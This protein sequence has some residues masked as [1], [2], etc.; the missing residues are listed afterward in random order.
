MSKIK[1]GKWTAE[2]VGAF[3]EAFYEF[4]KYVKINSKETG[5]NTILADHIYEAQRRFLNTVWEGL[6][7]DIHDFK[8]LK[9]RQLGISTM[10]RALSLFWLGMHDGLQGSMVFDTQ[11]HR[12]EA[13]NEIL[14]MIEDLPPHLK[15][16]KLKKNG[17][18]LLVLDNNSNLRFL[19]AG[20][21]KSRSSGTLGRSSGLNFSHASEMCSWEND[22]G[23]VSFKNALSEHY[24]DRLYLWE[25]TAR[26]FNNWYRMW[27]E[28]K[29]DD[30]NQK[31]CFTGW[32]AKE[33]QKIERG[34]EMFERYGAKP[35]TADEQKRIDEVEQ[36]YNFKV[37][38][39]Q[40]AWYRRK[41]DPGRELSDEDQD[42]TTG[43]LQQQEQPWTESEAWIATGSSFFSN[44]L[45]TDLSKNTC[46]EK[47]KGFSFVNGF[48]FLHC[49]WIAVENKRHIQLKVWEEPVEDGVYVVAAD[50]AYGHDERNNN[51]AVQVLRCYADKVEQVAEYANSSIQTQPFAWVIASLAGWYKNSTLILEINGPGEAV[52]N[53]YKSLKQLVLSGHMRIQAEEKGLRDIF[54]NVRDYMYAR[55]DS[56]N[57]G[58]NCYHF[59]T[60]VQLKIAVMER[61]RDMLKNVLDVRSFEAVGEMRSIVRNGDSIGAEG[62][63]RDDRT[64]SL[65]MGIKAWEQTVRRV[66]S[67]AGR[68]KAYELAVR[69]M[70]IKDQVG[71]FTKHTMTKFFKGKAR[72]R[73]AMAAVVRRERWR[74]K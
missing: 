45:L 66:M 32:W 20:V 36:L 63:N 56:V 68:T 6:A 58:S 11:A 64:Y 18:D 35:P 8:F 74:N 16:P 23:I 60:T 61:L 59:K 54:M 70:T 49:D 52:W 21:R 19:N 15:F 73:N 14:T 9:S 65:A 34:T 29:A 24:P 51:S 30:L 5:S 38:Q 26:G 33:S 7:N 72:E 12:E 2:K 44:E 40:L 10:S 31:T 53:E 43:E 25:S 41:M 47:Y 22:E 27:Q 48:D 62:L 17:R 37:S 39:E 13:R 28:A 46:N 71:L 69:R 3:K 67:T 42:T 4:L 55:S 50:P 1:S 57:S